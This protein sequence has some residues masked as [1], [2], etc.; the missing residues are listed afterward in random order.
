MVKGIAKKK[1]R[2]VMGFD[3]R[4]MTLFGRLFPKLTPTII[5][6]VLKASKLELFDGVFSQGE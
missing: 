1:K 4:S 6:K 3:G 5:T 2:I